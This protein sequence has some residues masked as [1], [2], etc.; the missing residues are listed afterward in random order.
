MPSGRSDQETNLPLALQRIEETVLNEPFGS[1]YKTVLLASS[2]ARLR[3]ATPPS[4]PKLKHTTGASERSAQRGGWRSR[5]G[6]SANR[7]V[8]PENKPSPY[9]PKHRRHVCSSPQKHEKAKSHGNRWRKKT[10]FEPRLN[11]G[12]FAERE[13]LFLSDC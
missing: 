6:L 13:A 3:P 12:L 4:N 8:R 10:A 1:T 11:R 2:P 5:A 9:P 7:R